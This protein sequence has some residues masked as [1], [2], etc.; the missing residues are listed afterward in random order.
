MRSMAVADG[1]PFVGELA[2]SRTHEDPDPLVGRADHGLSRP[3]H[4]H[5]MASAAV[6]RTSQRAESTRASASRRPNRPRANSVASW[7][8]IAR[9]RARAASKIGAASECRTDST[10]GSIGDDRRLLPDAGQLPDGLGR[11]GEHAGALGVALEDGDRDQALERIG[12]AVDVVQPGRE[13]EIPLE[14]LAALLA[15][16][17]SPPTHGW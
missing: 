6:L 4:E 17:R 12:R 1:A 5:I 11:A 7:T 3:S 15:A 8:V 16:G 10:N 13:P 2:Q 9:P 14:Q